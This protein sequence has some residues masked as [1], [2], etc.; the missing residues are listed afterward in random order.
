MPN[1]GQTDSKTAIVNG[2][3]RSIGV[4]LLEDSISWL[5]LICYYQV[6]G[7]FLNGI[8]CLCTQLEN[9][10]I[11]DKSQRYILCYHDER[12]GAVLV[13][14]VLIWLWGFNY[15]EITK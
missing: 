2:T 3:L 10:L 1:Y 14:H 11:S 9:S 13:S 5:P 15:S 12:W 7:N 6:D 8:Y 4:P